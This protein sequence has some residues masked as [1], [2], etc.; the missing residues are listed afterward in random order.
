MQVYRSYLMWYHRFD[1]RNP[2]VQFSIGREVFR[3]RLIPMF[4]ISIRSIRLFRMTPSQT[5]ASA[6]VPVTTVTPYQI[7]LVTAACMPLSL[8][9]KALWGRKDHLSVPAPARLHL[10]VHWDMKWHEDVFVLPNGWILRRTDSRSLPTDYKDEVREML[11][12]QA[13]RPNRRLVAW[14]AHGTA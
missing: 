8:G 10:L 3:F 5:L 2:C 12:A 6:V 9:S 13:G 4:T 7:Q 11:H 1:T 14:C